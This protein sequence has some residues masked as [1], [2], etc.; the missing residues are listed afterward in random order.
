MALLDW[1]NISLGPLPWLLLGLGL[2]GVSLMIPNPVTVSLGC[3]GLVTALIALSIPALAKQLLVWAI[4]SVAFTLILRG[5]VPRNSKALAP[6]RYARVLE[7]IP[8]GGIGRVSYDGGSWQARSQIS[9][10]AIAPEATVTVVSRQGNTL[11]VTPMPNLRPT[12][13]N[14]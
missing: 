14:S 10:G 3:A 7:V 4:L 11:I 2:L 12:E 9:D 5:L 13:A 6:N 1:L 8:P